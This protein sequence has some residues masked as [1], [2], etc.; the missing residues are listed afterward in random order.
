MGNF[1]TA[2]KRGLYWI[3][4]IIKKIIEWLCSIVKTIFKIVALFLNKHE[5]KIKSA[6]NPKAVGKYAAINKMIKEL[7]KVRNEVVKDKPLTQRDQDLIKELT[8]DD[9][10]FSKSVD[11][12]IFDGEIEKIIKDNNI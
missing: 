1:W 2:V 9:D 6:D 12:S 8:D 10:D 5:Q 11:S 4:K 7:E 3:W